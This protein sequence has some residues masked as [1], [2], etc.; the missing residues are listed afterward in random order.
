MDLAITFLIG[1]ASGICVAKLWFVD[2]GD[3]NDCAEH[4]APNK[5]IPNFTP[6]F[7]HHV[8]H[9]DVKSTITVGDT[10]WYRGE[11]WVITQHICSETPTQKDTLKS[12][13]KFNL[14]N[15]RSCVLYVD[16]YEIKKVIRDN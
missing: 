6:P 14:S 12:I 7:K 8:P 15:R 11:K 1:V 3:Q 16:F 10:V 4:V 9:K 13:H 2:G 5:S